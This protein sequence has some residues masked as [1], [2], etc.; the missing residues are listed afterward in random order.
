M[1]YPGEKISPGSLI[2]KVRLHPEGQSNFE[3]PTDGL[4][5]I[6]GAVSKTELGGP[7]Q[8]DSNG[9][10]CLLVIKNG[11]ATGATIGRMTGIQSVVREYSKYGPNAKASLEVAVYPNSHKDGEFSAPSD[12]GS[13]VVDGEGRLVGLLTG[14]SGTTVSI[15]VTYI[16]PYFWLEK[17]VK[18]AF[19]DCFLYPVVDF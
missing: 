17:R 6:N 8:L 5:Q 19:P 18:E 10:Q 16:T 3:Y 11:K 9:N 2:Y 12:S 4:L 7:K 15:D 13:I 1:L 14:G